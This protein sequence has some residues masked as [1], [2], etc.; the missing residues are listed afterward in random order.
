M[1]DDS[2]QLKGNERYSGF[3]VDLLEKLSRLLKF[4]YYIKEVEDNQYGVYN[5]STNSYSGLIGEILL[6]VSL[7]MKKQ[8]SF[9]IGTILQASIQT[10]SCRILITTAALPLRF[11][12]PVTSRILFLIPES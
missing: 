8:I 12:I 7:N 2:P 6:G 10:G 3:I 1:R 11:R 5:E 9:N 4:Q